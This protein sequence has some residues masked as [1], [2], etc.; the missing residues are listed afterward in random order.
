MAGPR[1]ARKAPSAKELVAYIARRLVNQ[2]EKVYVTL[3]LGPSINYVVLEV[4]KT[5][6]GRMIGKGGQVADAIRALLRVF[7]LR[8]GKFYDLDVVHA[9]EDMEPFHPEEG[10]QD[11][12]QEEEA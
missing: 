11:H 8:E 2:P 12:G 1:E 7:T 5:D 10:E 3:V 4:A 6:Y 9:A